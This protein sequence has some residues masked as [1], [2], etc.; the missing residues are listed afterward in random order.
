MRG[1]VRQI[2]PGRRLREPDVARIARKLAAVQGPDH[3][4]AIADLAARGVHEIGAPL[5]LADQRIV[6][7]VLGL[8]M[9]RRVD[10]DHV[11]D[12]DERLDVGMVGDAQLLLG[13]FREPMPIGVVQLHVERLEAPQ[14]GRADAPGGHRADLHPFEIVGAGY[15]V[16]NVPAALDDPLV[17]RM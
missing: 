17:G 15:A 16:G 11:A 4:V 8:R 7:Q 2:V 6:E 9:Q 14:H 10:R 1:I 13:C 5:H 12:T 3:S